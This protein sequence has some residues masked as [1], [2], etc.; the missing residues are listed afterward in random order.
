MA[1]WLLNSWDA[2]FVEL[3]LVLL[4]SYI[5]YRQTGEGK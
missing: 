4:V 3:A 5:L 1:P 2:R